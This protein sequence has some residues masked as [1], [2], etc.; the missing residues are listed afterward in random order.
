MDP[1]SQTKTHFP[2]SPVAAIVVAERESERRNH[3]RQL[4][5]CRSGCGELDDYVLLGGFERGSVVG[6]SAEEESTGLALGLQ[7]L[8]KELVNEAHGA[9]NG[10]GDGS[11]SFKALLITPR[12]VGELLRS[13]RNSLGVEVA[14][15]RGLGSEEKGEGRRIVKD[16][17]DRVMLSCVF[18][19]DGL[20]E[21]LAD[22]DDGHPR[23]EFV[24]EPGEKAQLSQPENTTSKDE[25]DTQQGGLPVL[26][27]QDSEDEDSPLPTP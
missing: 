2:L 5:P 9:R 20:W 15:R 3:L 21:V 7:I 14:R 10:N 27:I 24:A 8:S 4:G 26:E 17:L 19:M 11:S 13:L 16:S 18:D 23:S 6:V 25:H 1:C 22:L 12:P